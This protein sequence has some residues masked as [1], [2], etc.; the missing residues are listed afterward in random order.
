MFD[1][2][3]LPGVCQGAVR[4]SFQTNVHIKS[5]EKKSLK[6]SLNG[7]IFTLF[8]EM[9]ETDFWEKAMRSTVHS[10]F[11]MILLMLLTACQAASAPTSAL[12]AAPTD[13]S[14]APASK[15]PLST[16]TAALSQ[17]LTPTIIPTLAPTLTPTWFLPNPT[18]PPTPTAMPPLYIDNPATDTLR[19]QAEARSFYIGAAVNNG[20]VQE[21]DYATSLVSQF[22]LLTTEN[23]MKFEMI[24]PEAGVYTFGGADELIN[25]AHANGMAVRGHTLIWY[26]QMPR[27]LAYG[28]FTAE[29]VEQVMREHITTIVGRYSGQIAVWDV[30]NEAIG[31]NRGN[32]RN[33]F[34]RKNLGDGYIDLAF[35][36]AH[37]ADPN[38]LLFYNDYDTED[39]GGKSDGVYELVKGMKERGVP[40]DGVGMQFH[41]ELGRMPNLEEVAANMQRLGEL[42]LQVHITELD[43][44]IPD[45]AT[46]EQLEQQALEYAA[47]LKTCL[48]AENCTAFITW[49]FTDKYSWIPQFKEG[50]GSAL[51]FNENYE[52]KPAYFALLETFL[53]A[54]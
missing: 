29:Q 33:D 48:E 1:F 10:L 40:I 50:Y 28:D 39:M 54:K 31:D 35:T 11:I 4:S 37:E 30:V 2:I 43:I 49:G 8:F 25:F 27:W 7:R 24:H 18:Q 13:T 9:I 16:A 20:L 52:P 14:V 32:L 23:A 46:P 19:A 3:K 38:A 53:A 36:L 47:L 41:F 17:T 6:L 44:R 34:W 22:N 15:T 51:I 45:P 26:K 12:T 5:C 21:N 42:G